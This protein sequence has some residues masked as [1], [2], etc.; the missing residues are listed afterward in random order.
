MRGML[1]CNK[2]KWIT[3]THKPALSSGSK[4][5][6]KICYSQRATYYMPLFIEHSSDDIGELTGGCHK[7][8]EG[9]RQERSGCGYKREAWGILAMIQMSC[10]LTGISVNILVSIVYYGFAR[11][12]LWRKLAKGYTESFCIISYNYMRIYSY[13]KIKILMKES[14]FLAFRNDSYTF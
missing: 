10:I 7:V 8:T 3:D 2:K 13:L 9:V 5:E 14:I 6:W 11:C 12:Y 4:S 1:L